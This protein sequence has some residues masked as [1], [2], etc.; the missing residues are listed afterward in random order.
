MVISMTDF[1][2][3]ILERQSC[4]NFDSTREVE[5]EKL[6]KCVEAVC[7]SPSACNAQPYKFLIV[8]GDKAQLVRDGVTELGRNKFV[9]ECPSFAIITEKKATLLPAI[10]AKFES[11]EFAGN[12]IGIATA[13]YCLQATDLGLSTCIIGWLNE[14]KLR[15]AFNIPKSDRVRLVLATGYA[16]ENDKL[17]PKKRKELS[18]VAE[19]V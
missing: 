3:L 16:K 19:F 2:S 13:H 12:D 10:A 1:S 11:Q 9:D 4:R 5:I 15:N 14:E 17:R 8:T 7:L 6:Q 18:Q